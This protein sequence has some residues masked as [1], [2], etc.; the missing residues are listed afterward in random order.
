MNKENMPKAYSGD[1][2]FIFV[3]YSHQDSEAVCADIARLQAEGIHIW[4][5][6]GLALGRTWDEQEVKLHIQKDACIAVIF[7]ASEAFLSSE[8]V[9]K[10]V[11]MVKNKA[12][13]RFCVVMVEPEN[14][15]GV[16]E[17]LFD[18]IDDLI[19]DAYKSARSAQNGRRMSTGTRNMLLEVFNEDRTYTTTLSPNRFDCLIE[20]FKA[21]NYFDQGM[22]F[23]L[24]NVIHNGHIEY[25]PSLLSITPF[26]FTFFSVSQKQKHVANSLNEIPYQKVFWEQFSWGEFCG[27]DVFPEGTG[28]IVCIEEGSMTTICPILDKRREAAPY[29]P[30]IIDIQTDDFNRAEKLEQEAKE[31]FKKWEGRNEDLEPYEIDDYF[32]RQTGQSSQRPLS[33]RLG[34]LSKLPGDEL[35]R[36]LVSEKNYSDMLFDLCK[37]SE[38]RN[39]EKEWLFSQPQL[40]KGS[41]SAQRKRLE[42]DSTLIESHDWMLFRKLLYTWEE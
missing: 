25:F 31:Q 4:Y 20:R 42:S 26:A 17:S 12:D 29:S 6:E 7:Y 19:H 34:E 28:L 9:W 13:D 24:C 15:K 16:A 18:K 33:L 10:E 27:K 21:W 40:G 11:E 3:S 23:P 1:G 22:Y 36:V 30:L 5:D 41:A 32:L 39:R 2:N 38:E 35:W 14:E 8:S 37:R